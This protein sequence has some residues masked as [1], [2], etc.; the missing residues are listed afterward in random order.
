MRAGEAGLDI[1]AKPDTARARRTLTD[2]TS[3]NLPKG[4]LTALTR[5]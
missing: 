4:A 5:S 1:P 3:M 2:A